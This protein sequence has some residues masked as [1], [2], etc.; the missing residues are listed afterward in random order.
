MANYVQE[1]RK[2]IGTKPIILV[3]STIVVFSEKQ[4]ILLQHRSDTNDWGLPGGAMELGE[5]LE[6]TAKRELY[7]ETGLTAKVFEFIDVLSGKD[8]YYEYPHGDEVYNVI[9]LY[10]AKEVTGKLLMEDGE[11]LD[12]R[13]FSLNNLPFPLEDRAKI[14][15]ERYFIES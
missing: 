6:E 8:L 3:G 10:K 5:S 4:E 15:L 12:L 1:L 9:A 2:S 13:Y 7:E 11:S 14:I